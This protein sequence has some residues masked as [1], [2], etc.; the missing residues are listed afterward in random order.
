VQTQTITTGYSPRPLQEKLHR[1]L[2]RFNVLLMHRRFG[3]TVFSINE[4]IDK[5]LRNSLRNPQ[6]AYIAP[7]YGQAEK[8]AWAM[9]KDYTR[10]IPGVTY[11]ESKLR[12][13][14][15]RP[16][17]DD[18]VTYYLLGAESP[19]S[20]RGIY[21]DG[22]IFDEYAVMQ[23]SI[24]G[25]VV[26]PALADREGW[27]IFIGTPKGMNH[28]HDIYQTAIQNASGQWGAFVYRAS[29]TGVIPKQELDMLRLEMSEDEYEQE[30]ECSFSAALSGAYFGKQ[31]ALAENE[32]RICN[33]PHDPN[34]MVDTFWD[35]GV[36]DT[37]TIWFMQQYRMERR[38]IDYVE[39]SGEGIPYYAK[40]LK[41]GHRSNYNYR[42]H[43]WPHDGG[44]RDFS[45]GE[46]RENIA[47]GLGIK[48]LRV[49]KKFEV[50]DSIDAAR[51][52]LGSCYFDR[53][54]CQRGIDSLKSYEK[55]WDE[56]NKIYQDRPLHNW[57]S[58]G[59]DGFRLLAM[60]LRPGEDRFQST[61]RLPQKCNNKYDM[62]K[63]G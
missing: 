23:P 46:P 26:R 17:L 44:A 25:E 19:D 2:K 50:M 57:A 22:V 29:E 21:L 58:H 39:M 5:G 52:I 28:F 27:A 40:K 6:Y 20:I 38:I 3:K 37:T 1:H 47:R 55:K 43:N 61:N 63:R 24:F 8:I 51:R 60:V 41:E 32:K 18:T 48:P 30:F 7:T 34:L 54:K 42:E 62:F 16:W 56:K 13:T 49:H 59:A 53:V 9:L 10:N 11:N 14:I 36:N 12:C 33:V 35:L 4:L 45:T 31:M 15:P